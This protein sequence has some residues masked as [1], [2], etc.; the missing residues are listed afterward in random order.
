MLPVAQTQTN[1]GPSQPPSERN[2][3]YKQNESSQCRFLGD[4][5][6]PILLQSK[7]PVRS[8]QKNQ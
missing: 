5:S 4:L 6:A 8:V 7:Y 2:V 1:L 3:P